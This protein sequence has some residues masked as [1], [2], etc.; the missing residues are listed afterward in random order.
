MIHAF[1]ESRKCKIPNL[2]L[3]FKTL[4]CKS[5]ISLKSYIIDIAGGPS[6]GGANAKNGRT[7]MGG[8]IT[9]PLV[10]RQE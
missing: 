1:L 4:V 10:S 9:S 7:G 3:I 8:N 6:P 2:S 5:L